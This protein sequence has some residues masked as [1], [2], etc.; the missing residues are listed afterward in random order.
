MFPHQNYVWIHR[1]EININELN[2]TLKG[3]N[4][5]AAGG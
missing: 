4:V 5:V 1:V 3:G 2:T